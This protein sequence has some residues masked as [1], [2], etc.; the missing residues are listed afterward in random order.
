M[1]LLTHVEMVYIVLPAIMRGL[2]I[3]LCEL[4]YFI[5]QGHVRVSICLFVG[6]YLPGGVYLAG[7]FFTISFAALRYTQW[8]DDVT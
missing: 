8:F 1:R 2:L 7:L 5:V 4:S 3:L 6:V